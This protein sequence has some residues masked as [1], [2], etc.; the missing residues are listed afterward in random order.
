MTKK[1]KK[2][3]SKKKENPWLKI[4]QEELLIQRVTLQ[5]KI[6]SIK[7]AMKEDEELNELNDTLK[8]L[9]DFEQTE[10]L[11]MLQNEIEK[12]Q[13]EYEF[14]KA[15]DTIKINEI[16]DEIKEIRDEF[17]E[18]RKLPTAELKLV[19]QALTAIGKDLKEQ[20]V[21]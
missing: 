5:E 4:P 6:D 2:T 9:Q 19:E 18:S 11:V 13:K 1:A 7:K 3:T 21:K 10:K 16:K 12:L 15:L 20:D 14:E 8:K 17:N